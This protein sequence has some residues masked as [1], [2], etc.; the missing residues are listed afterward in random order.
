MIVKKFW[1][2]RVQPNISNQFC[3]IEK[4]EGWFLFGIVPIFIRLTIMLR[5]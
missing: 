4:W 1:Y 2:K 5:G 3:D